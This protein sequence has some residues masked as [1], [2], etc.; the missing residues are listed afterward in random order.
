M[1]YKIFYSI[2]INIHKKIA[3]HIN[4]IILKALETTGY[5]MNF[6]TKELSRADGLL[7]DINWII[8]ITM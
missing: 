2:K 1:K 6:F 3:H 5:F 7:H 4:E 8:N